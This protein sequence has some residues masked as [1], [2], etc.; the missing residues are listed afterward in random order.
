MFVKAHFWNPVI[1]LGV[2]TVERRWIFG[3][4]YLEQ[5]GVAL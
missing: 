2:S 3:L 5:N 1:L 4:V